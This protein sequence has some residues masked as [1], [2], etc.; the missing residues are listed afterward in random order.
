MVQIYHLGFA[1]EEFK[2]HTVPKMK[3]ME[4]ANLADG[5][6]QRRKCEFEY[7]SDFDKADAILHIW[8][9]VRIAHK[10]HGM[11]GF[12][13]T[14]FTTPPRIYFNL[15]N[16]QHVPVKFTG[17]KEEY[18][19]Y[20]VQHELGHAIFKITKHDAEDDRHPVTRMCSVMHQQTI[21][22]NKCIPG[23]AYYLEK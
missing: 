19:N 16:I 7:T 22:T 11:G 8:P 12:S 1:D 17:T 21:G 5:W 3:I 20:V 6:C 14:T 23:H 13:V 4:I 18:L 10:F 15:D 2:P 9:D